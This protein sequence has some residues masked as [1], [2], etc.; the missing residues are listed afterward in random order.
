M[1]LSENFKS[2]KEVHKR[3]LSEIRN[4]LLSQCPFVMQ[5]KNRNCFS[6]EDI[7]NTL[8]IFLSK[9]YIKEYLD[10]S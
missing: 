7:M 5:V 8:L 6:T 1:N 2:H 10:S 3:Y 9:G 4:E